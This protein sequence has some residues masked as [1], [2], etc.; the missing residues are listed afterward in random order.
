MEI[1]FTVLA[2]AG[3][4]VVVFQTWPYIRF[5]QKD[6][7][8]DSQLHQGFPLVSII[9]PAR[10]E[11]KNLP[12]LLHSLL[13]LTYP[14]YEIIVVDD[15]S[16]DNTYQVASQYSVTVVKAPAKPEGWIGKN[17]ACHIG[18]Q[19]ARGSL[20]LFTDADTIHMPESL[21]KAVQ[22]LQENQ[23][24]MVSA[25][26]FH[27][28]THWWE[29]LMGPFHF[30]VTVAASPYDTPTH[31]QPYA[32]GQYLLFD[33]AFY[34]QHKGHAAVKSSL[35]EDVE[36]ARNTLLYEGKYAVYTQAVLYQ[37]Q[38]YASFK[39]FMQGWS[40]LLRLGVQSMDISTLVISLLS[41]MALL[42]CRTND[43]G[44]IRLIPTIGALLCVW[45]VQKRS[46]NYSLL[47]LVLFPVSTLLFMIIGLYALGLYI[48]NMPVRWRGRAYT[49]PVQA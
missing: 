12:G 24:A 32:I 34:H 38:M 30:L 42:S 31:K 4:A 48:F 10:N 43:V 29:K 22:Y 8:T 49:R 36:L 27:L 35:T 47:G 44:L 6:L 9:I 2:Y 14:N 19:V 7:S 3:L 46:G 40:R 33:T 21:T 17:W 41:I 25:P 13:K 1:F 11:E 5:F 37:V 39:A 45:I 23:C 20:L 18:S 28:N 16:E 15:Q 26:S